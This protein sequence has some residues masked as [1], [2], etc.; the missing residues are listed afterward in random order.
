M[1]NSARV[2]DIWVGICCCHPPAPC[3]PMAGPIIAGSPNDISGGLSQARLTDMVI[4]YCG[5][6][7]MIISASPN[8]KANGLGKARIGDSVTGCT[9]G[10][11]ATGSP[12]HIV[13]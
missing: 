13:N 5:H 4:G 10:V 12:N 1:P 8:C 9:I 6:P 7:G 11:I 3:I 2:T